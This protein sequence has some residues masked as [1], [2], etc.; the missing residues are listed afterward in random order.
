[1]GIKYF[2]AVFSA[3]FFFTSCTYEK[4]EV[5]V[6]V[7]DTTTVCDTSAI[8]YTKDIQPL[9]LLH[10]GTDN[11]NVCHNLDAGSEFPLN[12]YEF[13]TLF[14]GTGQILTSITSQNGEEPK[15]PKEGDKLSECDVNKIKAWINQGMVQ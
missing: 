1:M 14:A 6:P 9:M 12:T 7:I 13:D 5:V 3:L 11:G 8:T 10:C 4:V 15:M 2:A